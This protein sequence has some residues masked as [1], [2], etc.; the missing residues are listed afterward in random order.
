MIETKYTIDD[1]K[2]TRTDDEIIIAKSKNIIKTIFTF[3]GSIWNDVDKFAIF[4]DSWGVK[5]TTHI[6]AANVCSAIVPNHC[7]NGTFFKVTIYGGDL[8]TCNEVTIPLA[9]SGYTK[10]HHHTN[11][12][13]HDSKDIFVEIFERL[14][15]NIDNIICLDKCLQCYSN[16]EL[17]DSVCLNFVDEADFEELI[18]NIVT[19]AEIRSFLQ[20]EGYIKNFGF[21]YSTGELTFEN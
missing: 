19:K 5:T 18:R 12:C 4:T 16:G 1:Q 15:K 7:L 11:N 14:D 8:I 6:G 9:P 20:E 2:M 3:N 21:D 10:N 13:G 17:V